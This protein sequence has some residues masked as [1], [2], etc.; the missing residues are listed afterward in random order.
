MV[1]HQLSTSS[2]DGYSWSVPILLYGNKWRRGRRLFHEFFNMKAV[3]SFDGYQHKHAHRFIL[4]LSQTPED[5]LAHSQL[6]IP[7]FHHCAH[8]LL[9]S[10]LLSVTGGLIMD[11]TYSLDIKSHEDPFLQAAERAMECVE[12]AMV[13]GASLV[14]TF[15]IRSSIPPAPSPQVH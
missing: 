12:R 2:M 4:R 8:M 10:V 7:S 6:Y 13:P 9:T 5:F 11:I 1:T 15:P 14:D 3:T